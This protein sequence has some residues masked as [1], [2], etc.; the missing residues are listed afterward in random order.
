M[1]EQFEIIF[2]KK[3]SSMYISYFSNNYYKKI[4]IHTK[5]YLIILF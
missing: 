1:I 5:V 2:N 3:Y 4:N